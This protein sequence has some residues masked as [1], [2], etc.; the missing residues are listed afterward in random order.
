MKTLP[1][2][3][4]LAIAACLF[5]LTGCGGGGASGNTSAQ[6]TPIITVSVSPAGPTTI[7][8]GATQQFTATVTNSTNTAVTW[9]V[10]SVAGGNTTVGAITASG[11]YTAPSV[12]TATTFTI[13]A[14]AVADASKSGSATVAVNPV[15]VAVSPT[16][17]TVPSNGSQQFA[18]T[19]TNSANASVTWSVRNAA[20]GDTTPTGTV[21]SSGLYAAPAVSNAKQVLVTATS[22]ADSTKSATATVTITALQINSLNRTTVYFAVAGAPAALGVTINGSGFA[23]GQTVHIAPAVSFGDVVLM[24]TVSPTS[25]AIG[26]P[27][28]TPQQ[29]AGWIDISVSDPNGAT[30]NTSSIG[31]L[32]DQNTATKNPANGTFFQFAK[33]NASGSSAGAIYFN[34]DGTLN[35]TFLPGG[36][37][38][39]AVDDVTGYVISAQTLIG[40][41]SVVINPSTGN[42]VAGLNSGTE[43]FGVAAKSKQACI[44]QPNS[45][46]VTCFDP[47]QTT[48]V[49]TSANAGNL[50]WSLAMALVGGELDVV[51][52]AKDDSPPALYVFNTAGMALRGTTALTGFTRSSQLPNAT[53][54]GWQVAAIN[55]GAS[56]GNAA[57]LSSFDQLLAVVSLSS[58]TVTRTVNLQG[59]V[60]GVP[61][62]LAADETHQVFIVAYAD[63]NARLTRFVKVDANGVATPLTATS[64]LLGAGFFS[65]NDGR[66]GV[67]M[68]AQCSLVAFQ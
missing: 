33:G 30:S 21:N 45:N 5:I 43:A 32:G 4:I 34:A 12:A 63:T 50:P 51:S 22:V 57:V 38:A 27:F 60:P 54:G 26:L 6:I 42:P 66:I 8:T 17:A 7:N 29:A 15:T 14:T 3:A 64:A 48:L 24:G 1:V 16:S 41:P 20:Q 65:A 28:G 67:C 31:L 39:I 19:V 36:N 44:T 61:F 13:T 59:L 10:N 52:Y 18:A 2:N 56:S 37:S 40:H 46:A 58:R 9:S 35:R 47:S 53:S 23:A 11:V 25:I 62:R 68:Y 55:A 49:P